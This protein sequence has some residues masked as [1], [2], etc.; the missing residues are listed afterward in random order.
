MRVMSYVRIVAVMRFDAWLKAWL[1]SRQ[2]MH[3]MR[4]LKYTIRSS[5]YSSYQYN[6]MLPCVPI[7]LGQIHI[8]LTCCVGAPKLF[9]YPPRFRLTAVTVLFCICIFTFSRCPNLLFLYIFVTF[10]F[11]PL[12]QSFFFPN[13][14]S[15]VCHKT[16]V[17]P[18]L[19]VCVQIVFTFPLVCAFSFLWPCGDFNLTAH[20]GRET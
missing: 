16:E 8:C 3:A 17:W 5:N 7:P 12:I 6:W 9:S 19:S 1:C 20:R 11:L 10:H 4:I 14:M 13:S 15:S 18:K 2:P